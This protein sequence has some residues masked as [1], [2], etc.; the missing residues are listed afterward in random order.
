[1]DVQNLLNP[2]DLAT[3]IRRHKRVR[4][5]AA[6]H[7]HRAALTTFADIAATICPAPNHAV[8]LDLAAQLPPSFNIEPPA[9][10][11]HAW[12]SNDGH[13]DAV[14]HLVSIA[15]VDGP[16]PFFNSNGQLL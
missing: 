5:T 10:H 12:L 3:V 4:L 7:V 2:A 9:F 1:M 11:L 8:A 15:E 6:G 16:Y 13:C 14:T